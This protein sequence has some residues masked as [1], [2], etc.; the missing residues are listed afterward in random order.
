MSRSGK[1]TARYGIACALLAALAVTPGTAS[2]HGGRELWGAVTV[3]PGREGIVEVA[4]YS[5]DRL[6][7]GSVLTLTAPDRA[8]VTGTPLDGGG[9]EGAVAPGGRS[10]TYTFTGASEGA[11]WEDRT[12]PFV[13]AVPVDAVPGTRLAGCAMELTDANG[14]PKDRG[15]CAVTVGLPAPTLSRPLSGVPLGGLPEVG[16][17]AYP[18]TQVTVRDAAENEVCTATAS[19]AD[20]AWSCVPDRPLAPGPGLLQ[21]TATLNGVS[22]VSE[23]IAV[24]VE[25]TPAPDG[26]GEALPGRD[27]ING[28]A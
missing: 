24:T 19:A 4:G 3:A 22:A 5:G 1:S 23:Q 13:L 20:G 10:A 18:G 28:G 2:A 27:G 14:A 26:A 7:P 15:A 21:A 12:F 6:G 11:P 25:G 8:R 9:Y 16:G 17:T